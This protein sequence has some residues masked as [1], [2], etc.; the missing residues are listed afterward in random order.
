M[1]KVI[2]ILS[3]FISV[4]IFADT[5]YV[6]KTAGKN[7]NKGTI[8]APVQEIDKAVSLAKNGDE[9]KIAGGTY[10]GTF[11]IGYIESDKAVK[12]YG[13]FDEKFEKRDILNT[14]TV[15]QPDNASGGKARKALLKFTKDVDGAIVDGIVFDMGFRNAYSEKEGLIEGI[16]TGR[17]LSSTERPKVGNSTVQEPIIQIMSSA[18]DGDVIIQNCVF[19]NG[20]NFGL[21][22][23]H[24]KGSFK[25]LNN[26]FVNNKMA[27][28]EVYGTCANKAGPKDLTLCGDVEIAYN[29]IIFT[30]SRLK[31]FLDMGYGVRVMTKC[32]YNIHHNIIGGSVLTAIDN[33][34]FNKNEWLKIDDNIFFGNKKGD[35]E[36]SP[37][38]NTKLNLFVEQ[39]GDLEFASVK[40]NKTEIPKN[41]PINKTFLESFLAARYSETV[42]FD[43]NSSANQWRSAMGLNK[44]GKISSN[45]SM[46]MNRYPW[47]DTLKLFGAYEKYGAQS[48]K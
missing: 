7:S 39:F 6:S 27:G 40:N 2:F 19:V 4:S 26:V 3:I 13:S 5:I 37:A 33:T 45:V 35:L 28:I 38:S 29:T 8:D 46:F 43:E 34:R 17:L 30:W 32:N 41:Y 25:V 14:P 20:A 36:F 16:E 21:Q 23:G 18:K 12:L 31:D 9:I 11:G 15:F 22:A 10:S 47:K 44:Q 1:K 42:D 24:R 48:F